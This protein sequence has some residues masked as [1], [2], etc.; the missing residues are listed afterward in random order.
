MDGVAVEVLEAGE[1]TTPADRI[2]KPGYYLVTF[3]S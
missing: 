1:H 2:H 3:K